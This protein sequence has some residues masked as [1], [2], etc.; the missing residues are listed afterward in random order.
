MH[1]YYI[2]RDRDKERNQAFLAAATSA[3]DADFIQRVKAIEPPDILKRNIK[4]TASDTEKALYLS[5]IKILK[6]SIG[7]RDPFLIFEDD[8]KIEKNNLR[9][10][11]GLPVQLNEQKISW[12][13]IYGDVLIT[14]PKG[15]IEFK[16][17]MAANE[18]ARTITLKPLHKEIFAGTSSMLINNK[19]TEK[20]AS[21]L[22]DEFINSPIDIKLRSLI[23]QGR[24][25]AYVPVPFLTTT[26]GYADESII[27]TD[28]DNFTIKLWNI[29]RESLYKD[30]NPD[31]MIQRIE[32][33]TASYM[34][35]EL[36]QTGK[37]LAAYASTNFVPK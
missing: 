5:H 10:L 4:G 35:T 36:E 27:Q 3:T 6:K 1:I 18:K 8:A 29:C 37:L 25:K 32:E 15:Y 31:Y 16:K 12:D 24:L 9:L 14:T 28:R 33:F 7:R 23:H 21:L 13:I 17:T 11:T 19:S 2:N 26:H 20:I 34:N 22:D 30:I